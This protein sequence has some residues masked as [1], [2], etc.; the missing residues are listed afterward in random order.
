MLARAW[1]ETDGTFK[2]GNL[3]EGNKE[4][5]YKGVAGMGRLT[6]DSEST[7]LAMMCTGWGRSSYQNPEAMLHPGG[8]MESA[9]QQK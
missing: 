7:W 3:R 1:Q 6:R 2:L 4:A 5:I 8:V 9:I